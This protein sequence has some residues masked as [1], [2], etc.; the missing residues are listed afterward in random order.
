MNATQTTAQ[1]AANLIA[2][3]G[4]IQTAATTKSSGSVNWADANQMRAAL[5]HAVS[6]AFALGAINEDEARDLGFPC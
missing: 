1:Y 6:A 3:L 5:E 4:K 2:M